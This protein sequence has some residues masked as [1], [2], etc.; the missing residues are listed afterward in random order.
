[1]RAGIALAA[2]A[3]AM[4][5]GDLARHA[6]VQQDD[7]DDDR[8]ERRAASHRATARATGSPG[9]PCLAQRAAPRPARARPRRSCTAPSP[10]QR[11]RRQSSGSAQ[12]PLVA[13]DQ[14]L[15]R[16]LAGWPRAAR[17]R[18]GARASRRRRC[19]SSPATGPRARRRRR[20]A[21]GVTLTPVS[22][23]SADAHAEAL[24]QRASAWRL[25][26]DADARAA[27]RRSGSSPV[28]CT[29]A[30]SSAAY[31]R[32]PTASSAAAMSASSIGPPWLPAQ[33]R[34][35]TSSSVAAALRCAASGRARA[36]PASPWCSS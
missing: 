34:R 3:S 13:R 19:S 7:D 11:A 16:R 1:M 32:P 2:S 4:R 35:I 33:S 12:H 29:Q 31:E 26:L 5:P 24:R 8:G 20:A 10:R 9:D 21:R 14:Q 25:D 28:P 17:R 30:A 27:G 22:A 6:Q 23:L 18:G 15:R 36:R